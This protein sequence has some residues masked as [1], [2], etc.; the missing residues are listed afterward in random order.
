[1]PE[2]E[3]SVRKFGRR[4]TSDKK[5]YKK[6][7]IGLEAVR[8][9]RE[10]DGEPDISQYEWQLDFLDTLGYSST[11]TLKYLLKD[12]EL[13][14]ALGRECDRLVDVPA[15]CTEA[16]RSVEEG[17][18]LDKVN[19]DERILNLPKACQ[20]VED[21]VLKRASETVRQLELDTIGELG[22]LLRSVARPSGEF[23]VLKNADPEVLKESGFDLPEDSLPSVES[24][25][26][27]ENKKEFAAIVANQINGLERNQ[28]QTL[29][30]EARMADPFDDQATDYV[31]FAEITIRGADDISDPRERMDLFESQ[32]QRYITLI[33]SKISS[34]LPSTT[35][36]AADD[37]SRAALPRKYQAIEKDL[38]STITEKRA[39]LWQ[40]RSEEVGADE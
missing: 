34:N 26:E 10:N 13:R 9:D 12:D 2:L 1:V 3:V 5:L 30:G 29:I 39:V 25:N 11:E 17:V 38:G 31:L 4:T 8:D 16:G 6:N 28:V 24:E 20:I 15:M 14:I 27:D 18:L 19:R 40:Y 35:L 22:E 7:R 33:T 37:S 32:L 21:T 23:R 36:D